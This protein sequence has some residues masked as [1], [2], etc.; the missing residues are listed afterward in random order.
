MFSK[1]IAKLI[2]KTHL[3]SE[4]ERRK[5]GVQ[6]S[7]G[8]ACSM[9]HEPELHILLFLLPLPKGL[10]IQAGEPLFSIKQYTAVL[11]CSDNIITL[12]SCFSL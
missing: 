4:C 2:P 8:W 7:Q 9:L 6:Q 1:D 10:R 11:T 12:P 5:T 3:L